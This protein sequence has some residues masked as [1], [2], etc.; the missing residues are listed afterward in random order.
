MS[1]WNKD[2]N[3]PRVLW[4]QDKGFR[5][6]VDWKQTYIQKSMEHI[7]DNSTFACNEVDPGVLNNQA[8]REWAQKWEERGLE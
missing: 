6:V 4:V 8:V 2:R 3:N 1:M 5:F 7:G